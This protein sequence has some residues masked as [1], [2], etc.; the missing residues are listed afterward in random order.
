MLR[1]EIKVADRITAKTGNGE[2]K[3]IWDVPLRSG[4]RREQRG[5]EQWVRSC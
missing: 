3:K 2:T 5:Q 4:A 1:R